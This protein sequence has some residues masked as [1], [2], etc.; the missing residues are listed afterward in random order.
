MIK[1]LVCY[2]QEK[3]FFW[4]LEKKDC[5]LCNV[6]FECCNFQSN[7]YGR[8]IDIAIL[9]ARVDFQVVYILCNC[10]PTYL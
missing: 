9:E 10:M 6:L 2:C 3:E 8:L 5:Y 7:L 1:A 4:F